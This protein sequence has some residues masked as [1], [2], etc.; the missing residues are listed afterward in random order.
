VH[1]R[2]ASLAEVE[3][4]H[5]A[6]LERLGRDDVRWLL[7]IKLDVAFE[8][9]NPG[10]RGRLFWFALLED[11]RS[12]IAECRSNDDLALD[13]RIDADQEAL[14]VELGW[15]RP[16]GWW[17]TNWHFHATIDDVAELG[18]LFSTTARRVFGMASF[19]VVEVGFQAAV[20]DRG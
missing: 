12:I 20:V 9:A 14:L 5:V 8:R 16:D 15:K 10:Q 3:R 1:Q 19:D 6:V 17:T 18:Q 13:R 11:G 4:G 7:W 2:L